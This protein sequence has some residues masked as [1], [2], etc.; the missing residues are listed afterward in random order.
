MSIGAAISSGF[1]NNTDSIGGINP[2][3]R[4]KRKSVQAGFSFKPL[5]FDG[6]ELWVVQTFPNSEIFDGVPVTHPVA[7]DRSRFV[8]L[9]FRYI[10]QGNVIMFVYRLL[11]SGKYS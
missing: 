8:A 3:L 4:R 6:F 9:V 11:V 2:L 5:E 7:N 10:R 1:G